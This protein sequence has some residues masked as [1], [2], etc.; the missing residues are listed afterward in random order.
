[1]EAFGQPLAKPSAGAAAGP[2]LQDAVP[3]H[4][5]HT[6]DAHLCVT[7]KVRSKSLQKQANAFPREQTA[8]NRPSL[9]AGDDLISGCA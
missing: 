2:L 6:E 7:V 5:S 4:D 8:A 1:M 3:H 9:A